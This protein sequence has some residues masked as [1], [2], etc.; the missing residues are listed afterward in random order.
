MKAPSGPPVPMKPAVELYA[1]MLLESGQA[2]EAIAAYQRSLQWIPLRT[3][4]IIGLAK[5]AQN[6]GD[7]DTA[8]EMLARLKDIPGINAAK[9]S[10]R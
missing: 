8:T 9:T 6:S 3:P 4:S 2:A 1:D 7:Q 10:I 5:A